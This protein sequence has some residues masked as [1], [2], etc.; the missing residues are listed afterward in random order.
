MQSIGSPGN[1]RGDVRG[2]LL[3][4]GQVGFGFFPKATTSQG[5]GYGADPTIGRAPCSHPH[6][7]A[8]L[9]TNAWSPEALEL[10]KA[11]GC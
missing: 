1:R 3:T 8:D 5:I 7:S 11:E 9:P 2:G 4:F 10:L 6:K